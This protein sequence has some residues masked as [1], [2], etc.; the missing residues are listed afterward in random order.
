MWFS[1]LKIESLKAQLPREELIRRSRVLVVDDERP[2][3]IDD[4][5]RAR[6]SVDY[7]ADITKENLGIIEQP[8]YDLVLL[9]FG[10]VGGA[11]GDDQGLSLLKHIKRVSPAT[12]VFAYTSKAL[13]SGQAD[14]YRLADG[15]L[16]KDAGIGES[17]EKIEQGLVRA[18]SVENLW[19]G[20]LAV[21]GVV[22]GSKTDTEWQD[23][24]V[25]GTRDRTK[26]GKLNEKIRASLS[27]EVATKIAIGLSGKIIE[28]ALKAALAG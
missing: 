17:T 7:V 19:Q 18:H 21:A 23:L 11:F 9:D 26:L 8:L 24:L 16:A 13:T 5:Q 1:K 20:V 10:N 2:D 22:P 25:R 6:F 14:F 3:L 4:L 12:M 28:V 27:S 15:V